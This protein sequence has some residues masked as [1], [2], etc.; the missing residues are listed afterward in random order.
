[1][2]TF[3]LG[4]CYK[5]LRP[6]EMNNQYHSCRKMSNLKAT[7]MYQ[8]DMQNKK[9]SLSLSI[10]LRDRLDKIRSPQHLS[11]DQ[12]DRLDMIPNLP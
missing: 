2:N 6:Q 1:M 3:Q 4:I 11:I 8:Q 7:R 5:I 10:G 9:Q 12:P